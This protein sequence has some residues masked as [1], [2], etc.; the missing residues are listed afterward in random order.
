MA[1]ERPITLQEYALRYGTYM[2]IFWII[3]F[4]LVP[5]G[6][7][8]PFLQLLFMLLTV[9][10]PVLGYFFVRKYRNECCGGELTFARAFN[11][12]IIMFVA[13][14]LLT[15]VAHY[16]YFRFIDGGYIFDTYREQLQ[17]LK[18]S[19]QGYADSID[20]LSQSLDVL[21]SITPLQLTFQLI[22][23]NLFYCFFLS[24]IIAAVTMKRKTIKQS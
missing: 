16:V 2:G 9:F 22:S 21:S 24:L 20:Q 4:T 7:Q 6:F 17:L 1:T 13:A 12:S 5:L 18:K 23:Q 3:K 19:Y 15:S 11:F 14:S 8:V 10:V